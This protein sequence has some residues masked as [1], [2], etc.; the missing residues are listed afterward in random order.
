MMAIRTRFHGP[1][2]TRGSRITASISD[3]GRTERLTVPYDHAA[4]DPF[5]D[6]AYAMAAK[7]GWPVTLQGGSYNGDRYWVITEYH[8][9]A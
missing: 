7:M 3:G 2:N 5:E 6:A 1:T 4:K 8:R 9:D